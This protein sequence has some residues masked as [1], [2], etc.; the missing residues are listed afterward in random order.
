MTLPPGWR[1][2]RFRLA[3]R[4]YGPGTRTTPWTWIGD[5]R[6][7]IG[8]LPTPESLPTLANHEGVTQMPLDGD[9]AVLHGLQRGAG[10]LG[11]ERASDV[12][13]AVRDRAEEDGPV[14]DRLVRR[15]GDGPAV[16]GGWCHS[17]A[18]HGGEGYTEAATRTATAPGSVKPAI[19][20]PNARSS[21][22]QTSVAKRPRTI[23]VAIASP[24]ATGSVRAPRPVGPSHAFQPPNGLRAAAWPH[25]P[26]RG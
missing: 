5:E 18:R 14:G 9:A 11:V 7:A 1:A 13:G 25:R 15:D 19:C 24:I 26:A 4:V 22:C 2:R 12:D 6:I 3:D 8:S 23:L 20:T 16:R 17:D 10:V 21:V